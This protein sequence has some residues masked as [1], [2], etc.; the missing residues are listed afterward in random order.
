MSPK[1]YANVAIEGNWDMQKFLKFGTHFVSF[2]YID[3]TSLFLLNL[4]HHRFEVQQLPGIHMLS[5]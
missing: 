1:C 3:A 4:T 5:L 2:L